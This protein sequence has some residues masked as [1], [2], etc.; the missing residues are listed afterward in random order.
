MQENLGVQVWAV[1]FC[2][3]EQTQSG[4]QVW[5]VPHCHGA[6][7]QDVDCAIEEL[8]AI[9]PTTPMQARRAPTAS[10]LP[11]PDIQFPLVW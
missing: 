7:L 10:D 3:E 5:P 9:A 1:Q 6:S 8:Q 11:R 2:C 4:Q